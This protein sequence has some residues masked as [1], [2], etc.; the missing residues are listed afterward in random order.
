MVKL[1]GNFVTFEL[2]NVKELGVCFNL[3]GTT[4]SPL[5]CNVPYSYPLSSISFAIHL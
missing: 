2:S 5:C 3:S 1:S 4:N